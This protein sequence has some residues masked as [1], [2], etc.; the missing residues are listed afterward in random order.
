RRHLRCADGTMIA[1]HSWVRSL[2]P[3]RA[4]AALIVFTLRDP[5]SPD[6]FTGDLPARKLRLSG[7]VVVGSV[8]LDMNVRRL[9]SDVVELLGE[10]PEALIGKPLVERI[11][12][13]DVGAFLLG[14]G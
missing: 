12:R 14:L 10:E 8:D 9:G 5:D 11:H 13:D 4:H 2:D 7:A 6:S 1:V 3:L